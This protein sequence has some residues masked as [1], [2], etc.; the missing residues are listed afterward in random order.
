[1]H[2]YHHDEKPVKYPD[3][4]VVIQRWK[5]MIPRARTYTILGK[6]NKSHCQPLPFLAI[7]DVIQ[8]ILV[9]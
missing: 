6:C 3:H 7:I 9:K 8:T 2:V 5:R 4:I 1:M